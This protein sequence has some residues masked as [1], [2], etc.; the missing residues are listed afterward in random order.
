MEITCRLAPRDGNT[1]ARSRFWVGAA[2]GRV[3]EQLEGAR[4]W[5]RSSPANG[6]AV[7]SQALVLMQAGRLDEAEPIALRAAQLGW[8]VDLPSI[9]WRLGKRESAV[10]SL[11]RIL[12]RAGAAAAVRD[13]DILRGDGPESVWR[14]R[15]ALRTPEPVA[16][17]TTAAREFLSARTYAELGDMESALAAI[18]RSFAAHE[19][20]M[21]LQGL[22]VIFDPIRDTPRFRALI[23]HMGLTAY[24]E[25]YGVFERARQRVA[26]ADDDDEATP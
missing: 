3:S 18:E 1:S 21:E 22:D 8:S 23:E 25:K 11:R 9:Q 13:L 20:G 10:E 16:G 6:S 4:L 2:L 19:P 12:E 15:A 7:G 14:W 24:H 17:I 26:V 5:A